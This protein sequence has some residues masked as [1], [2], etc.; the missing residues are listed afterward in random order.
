MFRVQSGQPVKLAEKVAIDMERGSMAAFVFGGDQ[1][2]SGRPLHF[3]RLQ[4]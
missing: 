4:G 1:T 2:A 3:H